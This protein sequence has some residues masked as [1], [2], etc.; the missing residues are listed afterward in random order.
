MGLSGIVSARA[1]SG[2]SC[3]VSWIASA[4][5]AAES[6]VVEISCGT[7]TNSATAKGAVDLWSLIRTAARSANEIASTV[8]SKERSEVKK[9]PA[10]HPYGSAPP[11]RRRAWEDSTEGSEVGTLANLPNEHQ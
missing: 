6:G 2:F 3:G 8:S 5:A 9:T 4:G 1:E 10:E 7:R 11:V